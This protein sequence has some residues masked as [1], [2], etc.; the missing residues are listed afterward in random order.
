MTREEKNRLREMTTWYCSPGPMQEIQVGLS[1][2]LNAL[3]AAEALY[4]SMRKD[5]VDAEERGDALLGERNIA[6]KE[7][8]RLRVL[9]R[10]AVGAYEAK[11]NITMDVRHSMGEVDVEWTEPPEDVRIAAARTELY[12]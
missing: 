2:A 11:Q 9:L 6:W 5:C 12:K 1:V 8:Y 10:G 3:D 7:I 4:E